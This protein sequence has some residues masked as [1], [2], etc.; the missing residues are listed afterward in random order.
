VVIRSFR[1]S[2]QRRNRMG[3]SPISLFSLYRGKEHFLH[4]ICSIWFYLY[5]FPRV[6]VNRKVALQ[7]QTA[8]VKYDATPHLLKR[9]EMNHFYSVENLYM[10]SCNL[11]E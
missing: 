9:H 5:L 8:T 6:I 3:F 11:L 1:P 7:S 4:G 10:I 2:L